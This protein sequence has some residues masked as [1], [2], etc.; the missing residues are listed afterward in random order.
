MKPECRDL[1]VLRSLAAAGALDGDEAARLAAHL[2][3]CPACRAAEQ[4]DRALLDLVKLPPPGPAEALA[5]ADLPARALA[6]LRA[7]GRRRHALL[8]F[9]T[10]GGVALAVAAAVLLLLAP[11][12]FRDRAPEPPAVAQAGWQ[13]PDVDALWTESAVLELSDDAASTG[14]TWG[15]DALAAYDAW[16]GE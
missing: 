13:E 9:G 8:R 3:G 14:D 2:A 7:R 1:E 12:L 5:T 4:A 15:D 10:A 16:A 6:A 11:V